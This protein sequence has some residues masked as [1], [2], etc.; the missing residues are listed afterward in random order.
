MPDTAVLS[1]NRPSIANEPK[2]R[3]TAAELSVV[4]T[5]D[6]Q[7][8][9]TGGQQIVHDIDGVEVKRVQIHLDPRGTLTEVI[10][11]DDPFWFEPVVYSYSL[12]VNA[13]RIKGWGMHLRQVDRHYVHCGNLRMVLFDA[14]KGSPTHG[15]VA[16]VHLGDESRGIVRIPPGVW[17]ALQNWGSTPAHVI[18]F[19]TVPYDHAN[20]DKQMLP[21]STDQ[22]PF[23]FGDLDSYGR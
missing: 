11:F 15:N 16:M 22:I 8:A 5:A 3:M 1:T 9:V 6:R 4:G 14:R 7:T 12:T 21:I 10:N 19:P 20:P 18:N 2:N 13:G 17:H 23:D